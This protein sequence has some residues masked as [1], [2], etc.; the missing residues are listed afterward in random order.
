MN[1]VSIGSATCVYETVSKC[2]I[3]RHWVDHTGLADVSHSLRALIQ[4][5]G[6]E[7]EDEFWQRVLGPVRR[8]AFAFCS[9]PLPFDRA[10][11]AACI[12]WDKLNLQVR[13]C[14]QIYPDSHAA[15]A[16][17]VQK[18]ET[19]GAETSSPFT[20][21]LESL[22]SERGGISIVLRNPR[23]NQVAAEYFTVSAGLRNAK[24]VSARQL[25]E[26]HL[27]DVLVA[28]GPC[29]WFPDYVFSAPRSAHIHVVS[30]CWIRDPWKPG[31]VFLHGDG[32]EG[33]KSRKHYL[34][35]LPQLKGQAS[36]PSQGLADLQPLDLLPP[37]SP[38]GRVGSRIGGW[39]T[40][41]STCE[42]TLPARLCH[43][44]GGRAVFVSADEGAS[45]LVIDSSETGDSVV[46]RVPADEL[47]PG[48]SLLLRTS[49]GGDFIA[50]IAD[51]I[52]GSQA[53]ERRAQ[54]AGWKSQLVAVAQQRFG[55]LGRRELAASVAGR[56]RSE[57]LSEA[58]PANVHY[59]M[60]SKCI[61]PRKE[62]D[63]AAILGFAGLSTRM[64]EL[65]EAMREI[66]R[67]HRLAGHAIRRLLLQ[68]I[69]ASSMESLERDGEMTF[70]LGEQEGGTLSAFQI[71]DI[72]EEELEIP[73]DRIGVLL[74]S[75]E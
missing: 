65:W 18:L 51:R 6:T 37:L 25:R 64:Q 68:K 66:D 62:A 58:R 60:S 63:F 39:H 22:H 27:C 11:A 59:W 73:A 32:T 30:Y 14:Q 48:L 52:L 74:D 10:I 36:P 40:S 70:A 28:I 72:S 4:S 47:E 45:S 13:R 46:R 19:L 33:D 16:S 3:T 49:G 53:A 43:L 44:S 34:G 61:R 35:A 71:T 15:L 8:L 23:M 57:N 26:T 38:F 41:A 67:A 9:T 7:A 31:P 56:L 21:V 12:E 42:E 29:G 2:E 20:T 1:P 50:P 69:A 54:Q 17:V 5:L 24:V 55:D 75:E